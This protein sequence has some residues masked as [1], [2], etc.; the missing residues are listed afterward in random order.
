M[1]LPAVAAASLS[2]KAVELQPGGVT[3]IAAPPG[4]VLV[5][6]R[7]TVGE[8]GGDV[9]RSIEYSYS[10]D[11]SNPTCV[12]VSP[13]G[14]GGTRS[15]S[16]S[17]VLPRTPSGV[18]GYPVSFVAATGTTC[19]GTRSAI[20]TL[21]NAVRVTEPGLN[22]DL[23]ASC[24]LN[25]MLVLDASGSI[26]STKG[27]TEAVKG[28]ARGFLSALS[29]TGSH[30]SLVSFSSTASQVVPYTLVNPTT[31]SQDFNAY[32]ENGYKPAGTTNWEDA[33]E[34]VKD[35]NGEALGGST[36]QRHADLV[37]FIT[38]GDPNT[39]NVGGGTRYLSDGHIEVMIPA[40]TAADAVKSQGSHMFVVG[41]GSALASA[42]SQTRLT[43]ISGQREFPSDKYGFTA[44]DYTIVQKF[45]DLSERL[46]EIAV[47]LCQSS[48]VVTKL[49]DDLAGGGYGVAGGWQFTTTLEV[50]PPGLKWLLPP[51]E[52]A[53]SPSRTDTTNAEGVA[54]F[55]WDTTT[56]EAR[57]TV[58]LQET[59][60]P[61][62]T[63]VKASCQTVSAEGVSGPEET[64]TTGIPGTTL[65]PL[66]FR[67]CQVYNQRIGQPPEPPPVP[68]GPPP[69]TPP[70]GTY[71]SASP[72]CP[73]TGVLGATVAAAPRTQLRLTK[74]LPARAV[75]GSRVPVT[76]TIT[77][78]GGATAVNV[79]I[80][81]TPPAAGRF[82]RTGGPGI[83]QRSDSGLVWHLGDL[84]PGATRTV[85]AT[86]IVRRTLA[87]GSLRNTAV[88]GA[89]NAT[90][91][92]AHAQLQ[93]LAPAVPR[94]TG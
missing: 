91:V 38:D 49:V 53:D 57:S 82:V 12:G 84:A 19:G 65:D 28:A 47:Q 93:V 66:E 88:G 37:V 76:I 6:A 35:A 70:C 31:I 22:E 51:G 83:T 56:A 42:Q 43:A 80:R 10:S 59:Q 48:L 9:W 67:T 24:G 75:V 73:A 15:A 81:D 36:T 87:N 77:N 52:P 71:E 64:S 86:M 25:V 54:R 14:S 61:G 62:Y 92:V 27:A 79:A 72:E 7:A 26:A 50:T 46:R 18:D 40:V 3:S 30:V 2:V 63:F 39:Y 34:R 11:M 94:F 5:G 29:G 21:P 1:A 44:A 58:D 89:R 60:Q 74:Q 16:F 41:V 23:K 90:L 33:L 85:H 13:S 55:R 4:S 45:G 17:P 8:S 32:L 68:V 20:F 69:T 78:I